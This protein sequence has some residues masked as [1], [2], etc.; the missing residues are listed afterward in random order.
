MQASAGDWIRLGS[1]RTGT[2]DR[3]GQ[4][5]AVHGV[6]GGPPFEVHWL[7]TG[8]TTIFF[9]GTDAVLERREHHEP[10]AAVP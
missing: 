1:H 3:R 2:P 5:V 6:D 7:D 4:I 8:R 9:P 10:L